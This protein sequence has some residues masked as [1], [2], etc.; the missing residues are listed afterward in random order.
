MI[1][2]YAKSGPDAPRFHMPRSSLKLIIL[3]PRVGRCRSD[4]A[5]RHSTE[6]KRHNPATANSVRKTR[7]SRP[8]ARPYCSNS[9]PPRNATNST[10]WAIRVRLARNVAANIS[11]DDVRDPSI[12][13]RT[14]GESRAPI[15]TGDR[16][17]QPDRHRAD[18]RREHQRDKRNGLHQ[19]AADNP[20]AMRAESLHCPRGD[21]LQR[22]PG[23]ER[24]RHDPPGNGIRTAKRQREGRQVRLAHADHDT[25]ERRIA[26]REPQVPRQLR[27][28]RAGID[29]RKPAGKKT[30][31]RGG[32][33]AADDGANGRSTRHQSL[34]QKDSR[35]PRHHDRVRRTM[36]AKSYPKGSREPRA[37]RHFGGVPR[38]HV[39]TSA[40]F[41]YFSS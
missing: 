17:Q 32:Q 35:E 16:K 23:Q 6:Q 19:T 36:G 39:T 33:D 13:R 41:I 20:L 11:R 24:N 14:G 30:K 3:M 27:I 18:N 34:L 40:R 12:P 8:D 38:Q 5:I 9:P 4:F 26:D 2:K 31:A 29:R 1:H 21:Q 7:S 37:S 10:T 22:G 28:M 25:V 15:K